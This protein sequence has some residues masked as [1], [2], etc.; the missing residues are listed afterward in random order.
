[1]THHQIVSREDWIAARKA[2]LAEEKAFTRAKDALAAKRRALPWTEVENYVFEGRDGPVT[3]SELFGDKSQLFIKHFMF[4]PDWTEG[5]IGCSFESDHIQAALPHLG[6]KDVAFAMVARAPLA[7]TEPFRKRMGWNFTWVSSAKNDFNYDFH[8]SASP[9][10]I[11]NGA[12]YYN[13]ETVP[14]EM[15]ELSGVS[16]FAKDEDGRVFH[17]Y[18]SYG[19]GFEEVLS[20]Y[21]M[22]DIMPKGREEGPGEGLSTWVKHHDRYDQAPSAEAG[23]CAARAV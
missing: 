21:A 1:M 6:Q 4:K 10:E 23:C 15:D 9:Q 13:Y 8:V 22:L 2:F 7:T 14:L 16:V 19:R 5:C 20:T 12:F 17:T 11:E 3:L 18:S